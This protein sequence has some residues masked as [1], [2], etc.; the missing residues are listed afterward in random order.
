MSSQK[1]PQLDVLAFGPHPDD[2]EAG[3][4]GML[5]KYARAGK[6]VGII[7]MSLG[8]LSTNGTVATRQ[9]EAAAAAKIIGAVVREN[10]RLPN[11]EFYD[12]PKGQKKIIET[13]RRFRPQIVLLPYW[14]DR[15]PDHAAARSLIFPALFTSGLVKYR[16]NQPPHRPR[17]VFFY[18]TWY[19]F[20]PSFIL[21]IS[22][23]F[24]TKKKSL[25]AHTSQFTLKKNAKP[26]KDN[27]GGMLDYWR[28]LQRSYGYD[29]GAEFGEPYLSLTPLGLTNLESL[30]PNYS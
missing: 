24:D 8:E 22:K 1:N 9:K 16:T 14:V 20:T 19:E 28:S 29:I 18:R 13:I 21:D 27:T 23:E 5:I 30:L 26:T 10:L 17:Y 25:L 12:S 6:N 4:A 7:D 11:N 2:V 15:H 3:C